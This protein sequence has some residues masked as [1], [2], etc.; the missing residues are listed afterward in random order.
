MHRR[1]P[2]N[3]FIFVIS[4]NKSFVSQILK[5]VGPLGENLIFSVS[6]DLKFKAILIMKPQKSSSNQAEL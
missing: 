5:V 3:F 2:E 1:K 4:N 6:L